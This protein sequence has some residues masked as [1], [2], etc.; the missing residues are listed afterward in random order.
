MVDYDRGAMLQYYRLQLGLTSR[1]WAR[2]I[3]VPVALYREYES[4]AIETPEEVY[5]HAASVWWAITDT[6]TEPE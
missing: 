3:G 1:A 6:D 5:D 4:G 2:R